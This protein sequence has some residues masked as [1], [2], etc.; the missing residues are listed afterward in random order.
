MTDNSTKH[1]KLRKHITI[2]EIILEKVTGWVLKRD[3][4]EGVYLFIYA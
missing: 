3:V 4:D 1:G 2:Q